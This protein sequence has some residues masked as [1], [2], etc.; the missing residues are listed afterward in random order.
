MHIPI[1]P[2]AAT[3]TY[4]S[5]HLSMKLISGCA[6]GKRQLAILHFNDVYELEVAARFSTLI[7]M[8]EKVGGGEI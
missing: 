5:H 4:Q 7:E 2:G 3:F 8:L 6:D 1:G